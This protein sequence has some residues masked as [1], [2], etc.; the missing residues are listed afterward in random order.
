VNLSEIVDEINLMMA[1]PIK[2]KNIK[3][4]C[5]RILSGSTVM[6]DRLYFEQIIINLLSNAVKYSR[7]GGSVDFKIEETY[8]SNNFVNIEIKISDSGIGISPE[9]LPNIFKPYA[10]EE[11]NENK[12]GG[13]GLGLSI[14]KEL[15]DMMGG[16][17]RVRSIPAIGTTFYLNFVFDK[18]EGDRTVIVGK[19]SEYISLFEGL[20][21]LVADDSPMNLEIMAAHF[22]KYN[23]NVT[24]AENGRICY[25][26]Y[27]KSPEGYFDFIFMDVRMPE[28][29]GI[30]ATKLIRD[31]GRADSSKVIIIAMTA[32]GSDDDIKK[33]I[34]A[35]MDEHMT[36]PVDSEKIYNIIR[37]YIEKVRE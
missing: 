15:V 21:I 7:Y 12:Y 28:T 10:R 4:S 35:G 29:D 25:E 11:K 8:H 32:D 19:T 18:A 3:Y 22:N 30:A 16:R 36:K 24:T 26:S 17:I 2:D 27:M 6:A 9:F 37:K 20:N 13:T 1:V 34:T 33:S 23:I 31:S 14:V 5:E